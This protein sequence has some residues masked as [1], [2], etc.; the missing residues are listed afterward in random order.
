MNCPHVVILSST[1]WWPHLYHEW[2][3]FPPS[4]LT[5]TAS[6]WAQS[7]TNAQ[8]VVFLVILWSIIDKKMVSGAIWKK[9]MFETDPNN[10]TVQQMQKYVQVNAR[11]LWYKHF[12]FLDMQK[13]K[14]M[15]DRPGNCMITQPFLKKYI[16]VRMF[17]F[18]SCLW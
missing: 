2:W 4:L 1:R 13:R 7:L 18:S 17:I 11:A 14:A 8:Y 16:F 15:L 5:K 12:F 10:I 9:I 6:D 3:S